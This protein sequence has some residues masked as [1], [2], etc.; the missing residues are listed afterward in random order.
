MGSKWIKP[1]NSRSWRSP[2][3]SAQALGGRFKPGQ[4]HAQGGGGGK[5]LSPARRKA[6][7]QVLLRK[8]A[9]S[10]RRACALVGLARSAWR[11]SPVRDETELAFRAEVIRLACQYGRYG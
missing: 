4:G 11:Y 3:R 1:A 7:A 5:L 2:E 10:E 9:V 8:F 6:A